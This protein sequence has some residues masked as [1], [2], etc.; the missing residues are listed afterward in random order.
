VTNLPG[1]ML[2]RYVIEQA[3]SMLS[4]RYRFVLG[5]LA[6]VL[7]LAQPPAISPEARKE[8]LGYQLTIQRADRLI[9]VLPPMTKFFMSQPQQ[10]LAT[11]STLTPAKKVANLANSPEA[12]AILKPYQL[13]AKDYVVG[14]PALRLA[15]WRAEGIPESATVF[16]SAANLALVKANFAQLKARWEAVDGPPRK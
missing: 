16:A 3:A 6:A 8:I 5:I 1:V 10:V 11:W 9:S 12:M 14:V 2:S 15:V 4:M 13:T 7:A